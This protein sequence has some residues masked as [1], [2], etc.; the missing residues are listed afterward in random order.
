M[1][2]L[3]DN[4]YWRNKFQ[5]QLQV[6]YKEWLFKKIDEEAQKSSKSG[7][8]LDGIVVEQGT[9]IGVAKEPI[10]KQIQQNIQRKEKVR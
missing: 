1:Q 9:A 6:L 3:A 8:F 2:F 7:D 10:K 5:D 4:N